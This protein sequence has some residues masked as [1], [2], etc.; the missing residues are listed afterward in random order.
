MSGTAEAAG[1]SR[2]KGRVVASLTRYTGLAARGGRG[3]AEGAKRNARLYLIIERWRG[4]ERALLRAEN[5]FPG[6]RDPPFAMVV[7]G[8][9][10]GS[11]VGGALRSFRSFVEFAFLPRRLPASPPPPPSN[12]RG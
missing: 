5:R 11:G 2:G 4:D 12:P 10:R 3:L 9:G 6:K 8:V 1:L 7:V